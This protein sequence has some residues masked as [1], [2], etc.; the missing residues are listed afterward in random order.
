MTYKQARADFEALEKIA[1]LSDQAELD[2]ERQ[3]LMQSPNKKT[4][5]ALYEMGIRLWF[6]QH[7]VTDE[8]SPIIVRHSLPRE[9]YEK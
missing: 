8:T 7:G 2:A 1:E 3:T 4:A 6:K 9:A 5:C